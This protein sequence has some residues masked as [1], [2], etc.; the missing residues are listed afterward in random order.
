MSNP[1][2]PF[3]ISIHPQYV[4]AILSGAKTV[5]CRK[6]TI[7]LAPGDTLFLYATHPV[8]AI[9]GQA[10]V[11]HVYEGSPSEMWALHQAKTCVTEADFFK[12]Y[13]TAKKAVLLALADVV[14]FPTPVSLE[15]LREFQPRFPP[16]QTARR[17]TAAFASIP[18]LA[19]L[20]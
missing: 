10:R 6:S 11:A 20:A 2:L 5:E 8:R 9:L 12:Y 16:P 3:I 13:Q 18:R 17:L 1:A 14:T 4:A 19:G 7:G 15:I